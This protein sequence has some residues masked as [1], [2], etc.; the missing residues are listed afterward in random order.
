MYKTEKIMWEYRVIKD[1][2]LDTKQTIENELNK[3]AKSGWKLYRV[4]SYGLF[5]YQACYLRRKTRE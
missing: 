5:R 3:L 4:S 1:G 2:D